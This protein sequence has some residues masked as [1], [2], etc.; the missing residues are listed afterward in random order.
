MKHLE[1]TDWLYD[2][3]I[4]PTVWDDEPNPVI[5][6]ILGPDG[7]RLKTVRSY[8]LKKMGY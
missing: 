6:V 8:P 2:Q 4:I 3:P 1:P 5:G 7:E